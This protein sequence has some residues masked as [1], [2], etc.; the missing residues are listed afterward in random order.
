MSDQL[1]DQ[2][3]RPFRIDVPQAQLDDL[4]LRAPF[5]GYR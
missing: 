1:S 3:V 2:A 4:A 5:R